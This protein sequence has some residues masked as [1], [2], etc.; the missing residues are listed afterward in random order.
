MAAAADVGDGGA[1]VVTLDLVD[2]QRTVLGLVDGSCGRPVLRRLQ[3]Y[4]QTFFAHLVTHLQLLERS[5]E[6]REAADERLGEE[7][8]QRLESERML[9]SVRADLAALQDQMSY[10]KGQVDRRTKELAAERRKFATELMRLQDVAFQQMNGEKA[11]PL[12]VGEIEQMLQP[13]VADASG[14]SLSPRKAAASPRV[15][16]MLQSDFKRALAHQAG[17][18]EERV[19]YKMLELKSKM[20]RVPFMLKSAGF[21][22]KRVTTANKRSAAEVARLEAKLGDAEAENSRLAAELEAANAEKQRLKRSIRERISSRASRR[23]S[24]ARDTPVADGVARRK[25][26]LARQGAAGDG[27]GG[28][29]GGMASAAAQAA[30]AAVGASES[31]AAE[32]AAERER[33]GRLTVPNGE[34]GEP[35]EADED[36]EGA[37]SPAIDVLVAVKPRSPPARMSPG[38]RRMSQAG[39]RRSSLVS[40]QR[41]SARARSRSVMRR[42]SGVAPAGAAADE[43]GCVSLD[44]LLARGGSGK[45]APVPAGEEVVAAAIDLAKI[46]SSAADSEASAGTEQRQQQQQHEEQQQQ[47]PEQAHDQ[48]LRFGTPEGAARSVAKRA[49]ATSVATRNLRRSSIPP[50]PPP[51]MGAPASPPSSARRGSRRSS[52]TSVASLEPARPPQAT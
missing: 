49:H 47:Q 35:S 6:R 1:R 50:M 26:S 15:A 8:A 19:R 41:A 21:R 32:P 42:S 30:L 14:A 22:I 2:F 43:P 24:S 11:R 46:R 39:G 45:D 36:R 17:L 5:E 52:A 33:P 3:D 13:D 23:K 4:L 18:V 28:N 34:D 37:A 29:A 20:D 9:S 10:M 31:R 40:R 12:T 16:A 38:V 44:D 7:R 25:S 48:H 27:G 51:Q